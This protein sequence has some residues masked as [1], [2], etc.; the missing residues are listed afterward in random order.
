ML[1]T[2]TDQNLVGASNGFFMGAIVPASERI[3]ATVRGA[4][5]TGLEW[6]VVSDI[7]E[8]EADSLG[9]RA[10]RLGVRLL[11]H[12]WHGSRG[13]LRAPEQV[14]LFGDLGMLRTGLDEPLDTTHLWL[15]R[16]Q[17]H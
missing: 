17:R 3:S 11:P 16:K 7:R 10:G 2:S 14:R 13:W 6:C 5:L 4:D 8:H 15:S 1:P 12:E 9:K